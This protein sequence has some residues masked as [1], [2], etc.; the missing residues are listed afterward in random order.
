MYY[1]TKGYRLFNAFN[2]ALLAVLAVACVLPLLHI[3]AVSFSGKAAASANVV[4]FWPVD[5]NWDAYA[6]TFGNDHFLTAFGVS[7]KRVVAGTALGMLVTIMTAYPLSKDNAVLRGRTVYTWYFI[8]TMLFSGGL[9]PS[10]VIMSK[11]GLINSFWALILPGLVT[12]FNVILLL[13]FFRGVPK[14][15]E[16]AAFIDGA[17]QVA[18]LVRIYLPV[19]LPSLATLTLFH[20]VSHWNAW[21]DG[22][23]YLSKPS[24]WPLSTLLQTI[25]VQV[26][27]TKLASNPQAIENISDRT[28]R[29]S[30]ILIGSLPVLLVYPFLQKYFVKGIVVGAVKE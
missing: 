5:F 22:M 3:L 30:Q 19:S 27:F 1:K 23:I 28:V 11:L 8:V 29:A 2:L 14:E 24:D 21:F 4:V 20:I 6:K 26:D 25:I 7:V 9:V 13:N 15:L 17:G 18:T 16:E 12:V 10:Y